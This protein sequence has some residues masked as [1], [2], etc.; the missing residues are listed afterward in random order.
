MKKTSI[1]IIVIVLLAALYFFL[2]S[3]PELEVEDTVNQNDIEIINEEMPNQE[4]DF[5][6]MVNPGEEVVNEDPSYLPEEEAVFC[7][8]D[9][10]EC[11]DGSFVGRVAPSCEFAA[12]PIA[13]NVD[14]AETILGPE[15]PLFF[16]E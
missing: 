12:C 9:A 14:P 1:I 7:T 16:V 6:E 3:K 5:S 4:A 15:D 13:G 10:M 11:P 8:M 2:S